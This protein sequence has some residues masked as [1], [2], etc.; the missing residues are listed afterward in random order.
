MST[1]IQ[2]QVYNGFDPGLAYS[3]YR[4]RKFSFIIAGVTAFFASLSFMVAAY[5]GSG[6]FGEW[7][8]QQI[9]YGM[10]G[11]GIVATVTLFQ[12]TLYSSSEHKVKKW[13]LVAMTA[14][15]ICFAIIT[16]TGGGMQREDARVEARSS[17]SI[18]MQGVQKAIDQTSTNLASNP[19]QKALEQAYESQSKA[20]FEL[21]RCS[22][23]INVGQWRVDRCVE[24]ETRLIE[25]NKRLIVR[26][27][28]QGEAAK[29]TTVQTMT[30][31]FEKAKGFERDDA[32]HLALVRAIKTTLD[33]SFDAASLILFM[34]IVCIFETAL[35]YLG[36]RYADSR[37]ALLLHGYDV[38]TI[39]RGVPRRLQ[40][41]P[42]QQI[43]NKKETISKLPVNT[44]TPFPNKQK[45][46]NI[47]SYQSTVL[48]EDR[49]L[50]EVIKDLVVSEK[51]APNVR[52]LKAALKKGGHFSDDI[53]RQEMSEDILDTLHC[54]TYLGFRVLLKNQ[55]FTED[56]QKVPRYL[57]NEAISESNQNSG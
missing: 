24:Y 22:R 55:K 25:S 6:S 53:I 5:T 51:L 46:A 3:T 45:R 15:A 20:E 19:Y 1:P 12:L 48:Q 11:V 9:F 33:I 31:L 30:T 26:L 44:D 21:S 29:Q 7:T 49:P 8:G 37:D 52:A 57:L 4:M 36:R 18:S 43:E 13:V 27:I 38:V 17:K 39:L 41:L 54:D 16:E 42:K 23:H 40:Q 34:G 56:G 32:F 14:A 10:I 28:N 2:P 35:H 50:Y 47:R